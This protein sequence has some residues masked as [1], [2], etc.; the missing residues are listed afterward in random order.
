MTRLL[1]GWLAL[2]ALWLCLSGS[3]A[4]AQEPALP[5]KALS[6]GLAVGTGV[7]SENVLFGGHA[8]YYL[9]TQKPRWRVALHAGAGTWA[10]VASPARDAWGVRGGAFL[11]YGKRHRL[12][13]GLSAGTIGWSTL[14]LHSTSVA[15][16]PL[17]G[18]G[19]AV[20][21]EWMTRRGFYMRA[22]LGPTFYVFP[23]QPLR[24]R[25]AELSFEGNLLSLGYKL[26]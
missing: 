7:G 3:R 14:T 20:G 19:L 21:W 17:W 4:R 24:D 25:R 18:A 13:L 8:L 22:T 10:P 23:Q 2:S 15:A 6:S 1:T 9:Q 16:L 5:D 11:A 26:W 12:V